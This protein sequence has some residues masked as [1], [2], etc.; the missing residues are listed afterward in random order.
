MRSGC[1]RIKYITPTQSRIYNTERDNWRV[2]AIPAQDSLGAGH[3]GME[4]GQSLLQDRTNSGD[5]SSVALI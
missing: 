1:Y 3:G 5:T 2:Q 4:Q